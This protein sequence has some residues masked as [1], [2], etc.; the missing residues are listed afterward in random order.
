MSASRR[1]IASWSL[2]DFSS[3]AF[4]TIMLTFVF[5]R[6]FADVIVGDPDAGT[7]LWTRAVNIAAVVVA[8]ITP[9]LGAIADFSGR[10][11]LFLVLLALQSIVFTALLFFV[12]PG[13]ATTAMVLFI[14]ATVGFESANVFYYAFLPELTDNDNIGRVS[15]IGFFLGYMGGLLSLAIGLGELSARA[16]D[17]PARRGVVPGVFPAHVPARSGARSTPQR[18]ARHVR[19]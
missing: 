16:R 11:K 18:A 15:G 2:Y 12:G 7:V 4:N 3:S 10:T 17:D 9:V 14:I 1:E 5:N 8:L 13:Q 6:F 19:T